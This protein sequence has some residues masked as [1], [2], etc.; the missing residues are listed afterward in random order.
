MIIPDLS[1]TVFLYWPVYPPQQ[2]SFKDCQHLFCLLRE[3][4]RCTPVSDYRSYECFVDVY[5]GIL[6]K[7]LFLLVIQGTVLS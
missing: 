7:V 6:C 1:H 4:P 3:S 2:S 5:S